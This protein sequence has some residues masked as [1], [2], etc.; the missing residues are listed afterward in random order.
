[1]LIQSEA[2]GPAAKTI[3]LMLCLAK[4]PRSLNVISKETRIPKPTC[5]RL[6]SQLVDIE[7]VYETL[8]KEYMLGVGALRL[9]Q[10]LVHDQ[11]WG[12]AFASRGEL[13]DLASITGETVALHI[14]LDH[15]RV[16]VAESESS[17][18]LRYTAGVG[19]AVPL[20][21][22]SAGKVLMAYSDAALQERYFR[23]VQLT[24]LTSESESDPVE[25]RKILQ[26]VRSRGWAESSGE[27]IPG[28]SA[29]SVP[30]ADNQGNLV[31][32]LSIL[33]PTFRLDADRRRE[34]VPLMQSVADRLGGVENQ[35]TSAVGASRN[36]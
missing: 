16:C 5:H 34:L 27:R 33:G 30:V 21:T 25:F 14:R 29:V 22:G 8:D 36:G 26:Q 15:D 20:H 31:M 12:M 35:R 1:V 32:A 10:A 3:E 28:A 7:V 24:A 4:G 23:T 18:A 17:Q 19:Q 6:L 13:Q 9:G 11:V 2:N